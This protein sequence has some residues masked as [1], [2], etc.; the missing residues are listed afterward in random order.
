MRN[1]I[2]CLFI[3]WPRQHSAQSLMYVSIHSTSARCASYPLDK[4]PAFLRYA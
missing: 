1:S 4:N 3:H 2:N